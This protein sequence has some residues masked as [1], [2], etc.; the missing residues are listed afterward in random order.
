MVDMGVD[1]DGNFVWV[2]AVCAPPVCGRSKYAAPAGRDDAAA[3]AAVRQSVRSVVSAAAAR[4][5]TA[6]ERREERRRCRLDWREP[7]GN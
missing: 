5:A 3:T 6:A 7:G 4:A 2:A 1:Y